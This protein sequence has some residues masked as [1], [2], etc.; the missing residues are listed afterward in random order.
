[1]LDR[2]MN[3]GIKKDLTLEEVITLHDE[4]DYAV[5]LE[6]GKIIDFVYE[7]TN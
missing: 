2:T 3:Y 1:M 5:V 7:G 4:Y 6:N